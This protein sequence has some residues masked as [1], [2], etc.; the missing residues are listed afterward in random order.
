MIGRT[1]RGRQ[2]I[3]IGNGCESLGTVIHEMMH[4]IGFYHEQSRTDRD[5]YVTIN[6]GNI[7]SSKYFLQSSHLFLA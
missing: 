5:N 4:A 7:Q 2:D 6:W 3:S 1:G